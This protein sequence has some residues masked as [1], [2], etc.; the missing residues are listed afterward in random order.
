MPPPPYPEP[1]DDPFVAE[2]TSHVDRIPEAAIQD[3][4]VRGLFR[5]DALVTTDGQPVRVLHRGALN[6]DSGPDVSGARLAVGDVLWAGDVEV[7]RTSREW[8]AHGHDRDPAYN[9]V[10]LHVVLA[11]DRRSGT[12]RREDG[13]LLPELVLLPHLDRS[14]RSL[15]RSFYV[16][17]RQA[18]H[19]APRWP[20]V[21]EPVQTT[22]V[23]ALGAER[24]RQRAQALGRAYGRRPDLDG[25]LVRRIFRALGYAANADPMEALADRL[26]LPYVRR[27]GSVKD[28]HSVLASLSGLGT[29]G[30]FDA[31]AARHFM[32]L[33][34]RLGVRP[35]AATAWRRGGR[36]ANAPA[37][38]LLQAAALLGP[39][40]VLHS[41]S[42]ASLWDAVRESPDHAASRLRAGP[43]GARIGAERAVTI[44]VDAVLPVLLL[45]SDLREDPA[46]AE[47]AYA[48][49]TALPASADRIT[50]RFAAAGYSTGSALDGQGLHHLARHYCD[51]GRCARCAIG[52]TLYPGLRK[53]TREGEG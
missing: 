51:E 18:P 48:A 21:P 23:R 29:A 34:E 5:D 8:E 31:G 12:L 44:L 39:G 30:L 42:V 3:A 22:W 45:D 17:P 53:G 4:W 6:P 43:D 46:D 37:Q 7:H 32:A 36:P 27:L 47:R 35:L 41:D 10:V 16:E 11:A 15:L 26:P 49:L 14:L 28:V 33:S 19:C 40:G 1:P 52:Q 13:S 38:R 24:L 20:E 9:R 25:L 2:P 50:R